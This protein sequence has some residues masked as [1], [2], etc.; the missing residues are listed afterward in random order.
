[1]AIL[2]KVDENLP[3]SIV[4][5]LSKAG[6]E[7]ATVAQ[8]GWTGLLDDHLFPLIKKEGR[9]F[10]TNDKDF[11]NVGT[12]PPGSHPGILVLSPE[13]VSALSL[14]QILKSTLQTHKLEEL[15]GCVAVA[16]DHNLV[17]CR[18]AAG[19]DKA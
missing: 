16:T 18:P 14:R 2:V 15:S 11:S 17:L 19:D 10:I 12:Y 13:R 3:L 5:T 1:M 6:Y 8:Q 4:S 7:S 9:F